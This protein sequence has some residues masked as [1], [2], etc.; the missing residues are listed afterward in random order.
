MK[1]MASYATTA[2]EFSMQRL[3]SRLRGTKASW[4]VSAYM[5]V[6]GGQQRVVWRAS[7]FTD[8]F[9]AWLHG[10]VRG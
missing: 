6:S 10:P 1:S 5:T 9:A 7:R 8:E 4:V 3:Q 2:K